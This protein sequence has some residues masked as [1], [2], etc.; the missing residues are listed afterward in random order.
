MDVFDGDIQGIDLLHFC[1]APSSFLPVPAHLGAL[2]AGLAQGHHGVMQTLFN[3]VGVRR[4]GLFTD[5]TGQL[6]NQPH[7]LPFGLGETAVH[8]AALSITLLDASVERQQS[9]R[10]CA[11][12]NPHRYVSSASTA[13]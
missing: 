4:A 5:R 2:V 8:A 9:I 13:S 3:V 6:L 10:A 7:P 12:T 11:D 1:Y